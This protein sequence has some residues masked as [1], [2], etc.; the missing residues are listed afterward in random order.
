MRSRY[1]G[2]PRTSIKWPPDQTPF[3]NGKQ[4]RNGEPWVVPLRRFDMDKSS[5][6]SV[7]NTCC[8]CKFRHLVTYEVFRQPQDGDEYWLVVRNYADEKTRPKKVKP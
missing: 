2:P 8:G 3:Q 7:W 5:R 6:A 1:I 4:N